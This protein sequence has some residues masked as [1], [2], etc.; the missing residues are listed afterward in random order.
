MPYKKGHVPWNKGMTI[1][2][3]HGG[4]PGYWKGKKFSEEHRRKISESLKGKKHP[5]YGKPKEEHPMY[6]RH[7]SKETRRRISQAMMG[8]PVSEEARRKMSIGQRK[9]R[10]RER[11]TKD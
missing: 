2:E 3:G 10:R 8:H 5:L 1:P 6:G 9:R 11:G 7:H 4:R